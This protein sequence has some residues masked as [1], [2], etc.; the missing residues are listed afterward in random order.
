MAPLSLKDMAFQFY[1]ELEQAIRPYR[2][3][4]YQTD[5]IMPITQRA[6]SGPDL[7][8]IAIASTNEPF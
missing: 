8:D 2:I 7:A 3:I 5:P 6:L 1:A 4:W